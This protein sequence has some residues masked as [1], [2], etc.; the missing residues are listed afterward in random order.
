MD[1]DVKIRT[2]VGVT[3]CIRD[4]GNGTSRVFFDDVEAN[5]LQN[6]INWQ[7]QSFY[8]FS[9]ELNNTTLEN[10]ELTDAEFQHIGVSLVAR[11]LALSGRIK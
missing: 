8:T 10:M 2:K 1:F 11:L 9:P 4:M 5:S 7:Y 3:V 6:P